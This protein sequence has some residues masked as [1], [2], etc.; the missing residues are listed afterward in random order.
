MTMFRSK[1]M[2]VTCAMTLAGCAGTPAERA[3]APDTR[4]VADEAMPHCVRYTGTHIAVPE[5]QCGVH[6]GRVYTVDQLRNT[7]AVSLQEALRRLNVY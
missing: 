5:G 7:G 6:A 4:A 1:A 2:L 3:P